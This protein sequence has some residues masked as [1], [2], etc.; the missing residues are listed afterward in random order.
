M[1]LLYC[2]TCGDI[3]KLHVLTNV[4]CRCGASQGRY[5]ANGRFAVLNA[6]AVLL[7]ITNRSFAYALQLTQ[8]APDPRK[9]K[10]FEAFV[11]AED[12]AEFRR[13]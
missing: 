5:E 9:G 8:H 12:C 4:V 3:R 1:K 10:R 11:I 7:G 2:P 13:E 6:E